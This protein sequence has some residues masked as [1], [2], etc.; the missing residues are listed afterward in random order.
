M[1]DFRV[2]LLFAGGTVLLLL[3]T[4]STYNSFKSS[5]ERNPASAE[6]FAP[7][8]F[9]SS[10]ADASAG[11][12]RERDCTANMTD[13]VKLASGT[14]VYGCYANFGDSQK[15]NLI[16]D[17][18]HA[19]YRGGGVRLPEVP[20]VLTLFPESGDATSRIQTAIHSIGARTPDK[21]G[22][23]GALL[24]TRGLYTVSAPILIEQSGIILRGEG[25]NS[26]GTVIVST[27]KG[28]FEAALPI[29]EARG[30]GSGLGIVSS[31]KTRI[32]QELVGTGVRS[33]EVENARGFSVGNTISILRTSN[34]AWIHSIGM[35]RISKYNRHS[36]DWTPNQYQ[37]HH[38]RK[39]SA[40]EGNTILVDI[41][42]VDPIQEK[43]GGGEIYLANLN[44]RLSEVGIENLRL[45]ADYKSE[46]DETQ[47]AIGV[48]FNRVLNGWIKNISTQY[49]STAAASIEG[50]SKFITV[51]D[52][53]FLDPI[54]QI[55]GSRRYSFRVF[56]GVGVLFQ[57]CYSTHGR[58][59]FV[60][61]G[62]VTGPH[63]WLDSVAKNSY[64]DDGP[65]H[66]WSTGLL[67]DNVSTQA[68]NVQNR[69]SSGTGH[70]WAG[71]QV[72]FWN[73]YSNSYVIQAPPGAMNWGI[74]VSGKRSARKYDGVSNPQ[75]IVQK[76]SQLSRS[77]Y[78]QQLK[79]RLG[80]QAVE[81]ITTAVQ[82]GSSRTNVWA[83]I[84]EKTAS[85]QDFASAC[86]GSQCGDS[87]KGK[88]PKKKK[89]K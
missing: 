50:E 8:E 64:E 87:N 11:P 68:I 18:S 5:G 78:L 7:V 85:G 16:P 74:N 55:A 13:L 83:S 35:D 51:Q 58:H 6:D 49:L 3:T 59:N 48:K 25:Q 38:E 70:G 66:R 80:P 63:V 53:A 42:L 75:G 43:F 79:D 82:R 71:A 86:F 30:S 89:K 14:L 9:I 23:R 20:T 44:G 73:T 54:S 77:L 60:A 37:I 88:E 17:F 61:G 40:I 81:Q 29:I 27:V 10:A 2:N 4:Q 69:M 19:G 57:R 33:F 52:S 84:T 46:T 72:M 41:P 15:Q 34:D 32:A 47:A 28:K 21:N 24:L 39:I 12:L 76:L 62:R 56:D 67:F 22:H 26:K 1:K 45:I 65:H 36:K 31:S